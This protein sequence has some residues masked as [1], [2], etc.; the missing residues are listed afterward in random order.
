MKK[1]VFITAVLLSLS[2][3]KAKA[4]RQ[5]GLQE[6]I[7]TT[8][9]NNPAI[10]AGESQIKVA[11][12]KN[13]QVKSMYYP[14]ANILSKY[15]YTNNSPGMYVLE[16]VE[17]PVTNGGDPTGDIVTLHPMA[18]YAN[19]DRDMLTFDFNLI[20][21]IYTGNKR[22]NAELSTQD[23]RKFYS[24][25]LDQTRAELVKRVKT[26]YY[27]L[28]TIEEVINVYQLALI[29]LN[30]HLELAK[31]A[32]QEGLRSEFDV[33]NFQSKIA[34]FRSK[35]I[36][37]EGKREVLK[38]ALKNLMVLPEGS[39]VEFVGSIDSL[40]SVTVAQSHADLSAIQSNNYKV[41][42]L[43][44]MKEL[45]DK[46]AKIEQAANL[47]TVFAFGNYHIY[48]GR[49]FPPF[50]KAWRDGYAVGIGM[51]INLFDG[52][53]AKAKVDEVK[54]N[55]EIVSNYQEG[56][57]LKLDFEYKK[58]LENMEA[59]RNKKKAE[60]ENLQVAQKAYEIATVGYKNGVITNIELNDAQLNV[61]KIKTSIVNTKKEL[62]IQYAQ[63][64]YLNGMIN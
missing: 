59:V 3:I 45:L 34:G 42:S 33:L 13:R 43:S 12:A 29:Q 57:K 7:A 62:L 16:G 22:K 9:E 11:E 53:M 51:K 18:P 8:L 50:D 5:M 48:H 46:K 15:F 27:N 28:I 10:N 23:L 1:I 52:N 31:K 14:Q 41:Q 49:D 21:P 17:M 4:Q 30:K 63:L 26:A 40:Y 24:K 44:T 6:V 55:S 25:N 35:I 58:A 54:A 20:Y 60:E 19:L 38:T 39:E 64:D 37:L 36:D 2:G 56:L 61:T 47:P 32:Y